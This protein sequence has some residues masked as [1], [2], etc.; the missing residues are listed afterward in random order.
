MSNT[1]KFNQNTAN[2]SAFNANRFK[3]FNAALI[4]KDK[5]HAEAVLKIL[6]N[7]AWAYKNWLQDLDSTLADRTVE[8]FNYLAEKE[9][10]QLAEKETQKKEK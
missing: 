4:E 9:G 2:I 8:D 5:K 1:I 10:V 7:Y 3:K 6:T